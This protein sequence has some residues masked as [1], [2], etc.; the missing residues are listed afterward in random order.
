MA[1]TD[2][3]SSAGVTADVGTPAEN[4]PANGDAGVAE[5]SSKILRQ[6]EYYFGDFNLPRDR[7][8]QEQIKAGE[9]NWVAMETMLKVNC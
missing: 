1:A 6:V 4:V 5:L 3:E 7:F 9:D 2:A 8:L